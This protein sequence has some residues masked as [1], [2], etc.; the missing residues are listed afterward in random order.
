MVIKE[1]KEDGILWG[2]LA[3]F[4]GI[5]LAAIAGTVAYSA[6][7]DEGLGIYHQRNEDFK[8]CL[9]SWELLKNDV[10]KHWTPENYKNMTES[11]AKEIYGKFEAFDKKCMTT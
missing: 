9:L 11:V 2:T 8:K 10:F 7:Y 6:G 3:L 4:G 1:Q 5:L